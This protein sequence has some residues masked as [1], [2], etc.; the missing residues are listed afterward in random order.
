ME[1]SDTLQQTVRHI[2]GR[3]EDDEVLF[4][5]I[6][7]FALHA[8]AVECLLGTYPEEFAT[9]QEILTGAHIARAFTYM[10]SRTYEGKPIVTVMVCS[11]KHCLSLI[12][13][14]AEWDPNHLRLFRALSIEAEEYDPYEDWLTRFAQPVQMNWADESAIEKFA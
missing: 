6:Q 1:I 8:P 4:N 7:S 5:C 11:E 12:N 3:T 9:D 14:V 10:A 13:G 2:L